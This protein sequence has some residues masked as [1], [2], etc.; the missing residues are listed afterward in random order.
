MIQKSLSIIVTLGFAAVVALT[1][2]G[3]RP[4]EQLPPDAAFEAPAVKAESRPG[5]RFIGAWVPPG[6]AEG[7][8]GVLLISRDEEQFL[9][10]LIAPQSDDQVM[11][12]LE[13]RLKSA[14]VLVGTVA[15]EDRE[16]EMS[17]ELTPETGMLLITFVHDDGDFEAWLMVRDEFQDEVLQEVEKQSLSNEEKAAVQK[18]LEDP[19]VAEILKAREEDGAVIRTSV[20]ARDANGFFVIIRVFKV[21]GAPDSPVSRTLG[22]YRVDLKTGDVTRTAL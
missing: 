9:G 19:E 13:L 3:C 2:T 5:D 17:A 1:S 6:E 12:V 18:V 14:N 21:A 10:E 11:A 20:D 22:W 15:L 4:T 8:V 16:F 7:N